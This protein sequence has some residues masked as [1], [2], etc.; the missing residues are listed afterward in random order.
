[1]DKRL[2]GIIAQMTVYYQI[3]TEFLLP[4]YVFLTFD[5]YTGA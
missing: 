2:Q 4:A 1:L 3:L 5:L